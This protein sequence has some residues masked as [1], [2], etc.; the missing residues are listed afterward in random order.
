MTGFVGQDTHAD[1]QQRLWHLMHCWVDTGWWR[2]E[3]G[4]I[5]LGHIRPHYP[6]STIPAAVRYLDIF[7]V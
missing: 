1:Y 3:G 6:N 7:A 5:F 4:N 2:Y